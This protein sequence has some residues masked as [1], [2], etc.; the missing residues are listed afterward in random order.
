MEFLFFVRKEIMDLG[1][2]KMIVHTYLFSG[3][4]GIDEQDKPDDEEAG[5]G[6]Y[7]IAHIA[8]HMFNKTKRK[9][10]KDDRQSFSHREK[11]KI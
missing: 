1:F 2:E 9:Q 4:L 10:P 8:G 3:P 6:K 7:R 5:Q 11:A